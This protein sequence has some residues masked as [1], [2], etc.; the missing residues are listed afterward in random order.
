MTF[1]DLTGTLQGGIIKMER[2]MDI[3]K[4]NKTTWRIQTDKD[5]IVIMLEHGAVNFYRHDDS[6]ADISDDKD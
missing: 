6:I 2:E 5:A 4:I 3:F 1:R